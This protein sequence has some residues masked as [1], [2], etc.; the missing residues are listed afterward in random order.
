MS[1]NYKV[2]SEIDPFNDNFVTGI[3]Y[4]E[5][6][7]YGDILIKKVNDKEVEQYIHTT[8]KIYYPGD[9]DSMYKMKFDDQETYEDFFVF[10]KLDGTNICRFTYEDSYGKK[11]V[12]YKTRLTPFLKDGSHEKYYTLWNK[13][14]SKYPCINSLSDDYAYGFELYGNINKH[15]IKYDVELD[16]RILYKISKY[17]NIE[18]PPLSSD[19]DVKPPKYAYYSLCMVVNMN[20][21]NNE[22]KKD[23]DYYSLRINQIDDDEKLEIPKFDGIKNIYD[24]YVEKSRKRFEIDK[25]S[26]G[27]VFYI[28]KGGKVIKVWKCKPEIVIKS[29][30]DKNSG[31]QYIGDLDIETTCINALESVSDLSIENLKTETKKL[32]S[33]T[34][35][36]LQIEVSKEFINNIVKKVFEESNMKKKIFYEYEKIKKE[37]F[38]FSTH[39]KEVLGKLSLL[40]DKKEMSFVFKILNTYYS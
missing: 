19:V 32:L 26:E 9:V 10:D 3:V 11:F 33:E 5:E 7:K 1:E 21:R 17:G 25:S 4:T 12:S 18:L 31:I 20:D 14:L 39:K 15:L 40:F 29:D 23:D 24:M 38:L 16:T 2:F 36:E 6:S 35:T 22:N 8:P 28:I 37:G 30:I 34:Y 27:Y 13:I